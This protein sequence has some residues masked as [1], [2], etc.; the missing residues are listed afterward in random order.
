MKI[1]SRIVWSKVERKVDVVSYENPTDAVVENTFSTAKRKEEPQQQDQKVQNFNS[2]HSC[3][4][5]LK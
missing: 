4:K 3:S 2:P 1:A 5:L